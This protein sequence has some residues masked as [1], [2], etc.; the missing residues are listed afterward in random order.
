MAKDNELSNLVKQLK[1]EFTEKQP[2]GRPPLTGEKL[3]VYLDTERAASLKAKR[4]EIDIETVVPGIEGIYK[5]LRN[6]EVHFQKEYADPAADE[7][8]KAFSDGAGFVVSELIPLIMSL[9]EQA[10]I[11]TH[12]RP[13]LSE[14]N[15][16]YSQIRK[17]IKEHGWQSEEAQK[18][19]ES[20]YGSLDMAVSKLD[21]IE[22]ENGK[23]T[24][25]DFRMVYNKYEL[26]SES[27]PNLNDRHVKPLRYTD[28][29]SEP[30]WKSFRRWYNNEKT[31]LDS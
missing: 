17:L 27:N 22:A 1:P 9:R 20:L 29:G 28:S 18:Q 4:K 10:G 2:T 8:D 13:S 15:P 3:Q 16:G 24:A 11:I 21:Q 31:N 7:T 25:E 5:K 14:L 19:L 30:G 6:L 26:F 23:I 12:G